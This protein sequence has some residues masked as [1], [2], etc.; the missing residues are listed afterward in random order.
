[1]SLIN[2][3]HNRVYGTVNMPRQEASMVQIGIATAMR[4]MYIPRLDANHRLGALERD[5]IS[6]ADRRKMGDI[7]HINRHAF[8]A[9]DALSYDSLV[10]ENVPNSAHRDQ[11]RPGNYK[12]DEETYRTLAEIATR[13]KF[14]YMSYINDQDRRYHYQYPNLEQRPW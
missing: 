14:K 8:N 5:F 1:M 9:D 13:Y 3:D 11:I 12:W 2:N 6:A 4:N 10:G 7:V